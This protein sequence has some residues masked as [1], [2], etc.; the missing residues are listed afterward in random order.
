M[1]IPIANGDMAWKELI[2]DL[3]AL[4]AD[5]EVVFV[6]ADQSLRLLRKNS[7][8]ES[9]ICQ[10]SFLSISD[11]GR[12]RQLNA[13]EKAARN[14]FLWFLHCDCRFSKEA[15]EAL[16]GAFS[17][18]PEALHFFDLR[19]SDDGPPFMRLNELGVWIRSRMLRLPF[20]DQGLAISRSAFKR[21][22]GFCES[23]PY[24]EDHL[25]VWRAHRAAVKLRCVG[26]TLRTSAR[27]YESNGWRRTTT[28]HLMLT[29]KQAFP[30]FV[31]FLKERVHL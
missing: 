17:R 16:A 31:R 30:E 13:G 7:S 11:M 10:Q 8:L 28:N 2:P 19:F 29:A 27:K 1:I 22:G 9:L 15:F 25:L 26:S 18:E 12:A 23:A 4:G 24:G 14:N 5:D 21:L 3:R 20:G 6:G